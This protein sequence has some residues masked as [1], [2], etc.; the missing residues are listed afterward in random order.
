MD[1]GWIVPIKM[2]I[3]H[4]DLAGALIITLV[5]DCSPEINVPEP[6]AY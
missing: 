5:T 1:A 2:N 6:D 3:K 4:P